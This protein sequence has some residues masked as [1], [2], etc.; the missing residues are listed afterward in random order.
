MPTTRVIRVRLLA[1]ALIL[2]VLGGICA[3][4]YMGMREQQAFFAKATKQV[5]SVTGKEERKSGGSRRNK[6]KQYYLTV[7]LFGGDTA[8]RHIQL[9]DTGIV[10]TPKEVLF[11]K[12]NEISASMQQ[13]APL[14]DHIKG[15]IM[16]PGEVFVSVQ[17]GDKIM[18]AFDPAKPTDIRFHSTIPKQ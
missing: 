1:F 12:L 9:P 16:V 18:V 3:L 15:I 5:A 4:V 8:N 10:G 2:L 7:A 17:P 11:K 13:A 14:G 6:S